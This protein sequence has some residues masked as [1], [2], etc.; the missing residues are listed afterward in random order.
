MAKKK[1]K[2]KTKRKLTAKQ[3]RALAKGRATMKKRAAAK[4]R[5]AKKAKRKR[6][7]NPAYGNFLSASR[8]A[9]RH[10]KNPVRASSRAV[11]KYYIVNRT[12]K[13]NRYYDGLGFST[14]LSTAAT[15]KDLPAAKRVA[16]ALA[17]H[18]GKKVSVYDGSL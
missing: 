5:T 7:A 6:R 4:K 11:P 17:D 10:G 18:T 2:R 14:K 8:A 15:W 3:L 9:I 12:G 16:Q 13:T 1:A